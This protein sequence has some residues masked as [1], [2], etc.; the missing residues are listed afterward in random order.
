MWPTMLS[1]FTTSFLAV[2]DKPSVEEVEEDVEDDVN[3]CEE[4]DESDN[5][6]RKENKEK[7]ITVEDIKP[8]LILRRKGGFVSCVHMATRGN[9]LQP[10]VVQSR[11][12]TL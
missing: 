9:M 5:S 6:D 10:R 8:G 12:F 7:N 4:N 2:F 11:G 1:W 3:N